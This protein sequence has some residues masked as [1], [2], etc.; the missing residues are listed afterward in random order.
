MYRHFVFHIVGVLCVAIAMV[1]LWQLPVLI[2]GNAYD[3]FPL[4]LTRNV[5]EVGTFATTDAIGRFLSTAQIPEISVLATE[6][7]RMSAYLLSWF[8]PY[9]QWQNL[10]GWSVVASATMA[11][12]LVFWWLAVAKWFSRNVAWISTCILAFMP[13]Y[14]RQAVWLDNYNFAFLFLFASFAAFAYLR[15]KS[16]WLALAASGLCFGLSVASKD[17]FL[18]FVPWIIFAYGWF[19]RAHWKQAVL[20]LGIFFAAVTSMY[21]LPYVGDVLEQGYPSNYNLAHF[22][23]AKAEIR[24]GFYL[25]LYPDPY[26]YFFQKDAYDQ[27]L[28]ATYE[29]SGFLQKMRYQKIFINF[30]VGQPSFVMKLL[31]GV[32]LF[33][34]AFPAWFQVQTF[35]GAVLWLFLLPGMYFFWRAHRKEAWWFIGLVVS[36]ECVMRFVLHYSRDHSMDYAWGFALVAAFGVVEAARSSRRAQ[37]FI[38]AVLVVCLVQANRVVLANSYR[39][40]PTATMLAAAEALQT[41]PNNAVIA[42]GVGSSKAEQLAYLSD[43]TVALFNEATVQNLVE[44]NEL[45]SAFEQYGI[46]HVYGFSDALTPT[47][48]KQVQ[49]VRVLPTVVDMPLRRSSDSLNFLLHLIR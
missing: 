42:V 43:R 47:I 28:L 17:A 31:N 38:T 22:W 40:A 7:G 34:G 44:S 49:D 46:T 25:H 30:D 4:L 33:I 23:P 21:A 9:I 1:C 29:Q 48:L 24:E 39:H 11:L 6:D 2:A 26:T 35:G 3:V 37:I 10:V 8:A 15:Q 5:A 14:W 45:Q 20:G 19:Y 18:V 32:W 41:T 13:L 36:S 12:A 27:Q 16:H